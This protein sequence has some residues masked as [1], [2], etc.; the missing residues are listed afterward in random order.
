MMYGDVNPFMDLAQGD[1]SDDEI[2]TT[3]TSD[4]KKN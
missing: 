4:A 1:T 2:E 3:T